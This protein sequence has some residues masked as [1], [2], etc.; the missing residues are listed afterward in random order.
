MKTL[1][2]IQDLH[3]YFYLRKGISKVVNGL[4]LSVREGELLGVVG[5]S[6]SGKTVT[7][8]SVVNRVRMPG[9]VV[10]G[11]VIY[12]GQDLLKLSEEELRKYRGKEI[13]LIAANARGNLNPLVKVGN[14]IANV[15]L[16]HNKVNK[17]E[18]WE[19]AVEMLRMVG[20][21]DALRRAEAYPHEMSGGMAQRVMIALAL[22]NS[23]NLLI[24]D[25]ATNGLDV[26]VQSQIMDLILDIVN[27]QG[28]S[29]ILITHDLG[30]VAQCCSEI[31]IMYCGQIVEKG[32][33]TA[34]FDEPKHPYSRNLLNSLPERRITQ[35]R[36]ELKGSL[37]SPLSLPTGCVY[38][39]RCPYVMDVCRK[40]EPSMLH[41][42][43]NYNVKCHLYQEKTENR[44]SA[45]EKLA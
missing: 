2:Q 23:P 33:V 26:T 22:V 4:Q 9:K 8:M 11:K 12:Q 35:E 21:N 14:Q 29:G 16:A 15:Y 34:F 30:V 25:D 5:E 24:A 13:G 41:V 39:T 28:A 20:M 27:K 36:I 40:V 1:L 3:T 44:G 32:P 6:G 7:A 45:N 38:Q 19:K 10:K 31:A 17:K 37:S 42:D 43:D 18:A